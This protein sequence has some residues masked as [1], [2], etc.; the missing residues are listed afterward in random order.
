MQGTVQLFCIRGGRLV[1][2]TRLGWPA[3]RR[4]LG[5]LIRAAFRGEGP[6]TMTPEAAAEATVVAGWLRQQQKRADTTVIAV[7]PSQPADALAAI[8]ADLDR[9]AAASVP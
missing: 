2:Q 1:R 7:D 8:R 9:R 3:E 5:P 6:A 4:G